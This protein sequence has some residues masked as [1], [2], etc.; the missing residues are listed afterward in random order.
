VLDEA[1]RDARIRASGLNDS[2]RR[3]VAD[4]APIDGYGVGA[5]RHRGRPGRRIPGGALGAVYKEVWSEGKAPRQGEGG[6]RQEHLAGC[7]QVYRAGCWATYR[8][9]EEPRPPD[10]A[11]LL[12]PVMHGDEILSGAAPPLPE[13]IAAA[14]ENLARLPERYHALED[15]PAYPV[16][17]SDA[18]VRLRDEAIA[19]YT[20]EF[21]AQSSKFQ[22]RT[23]FL[24]L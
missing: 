22:A 18:L 5:I 23:G 16:R 1:G 24:E 11:A 9:V 8:A 10:G 19:H 7:E 12:A 3:A 14:R 6:G 15:A 13:I 2:N 20:S 17:F 21:Q 4:G